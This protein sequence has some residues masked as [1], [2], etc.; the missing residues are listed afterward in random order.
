MLVRNWMTKDV[1]T[2]TPETSLLKIGKLMR[3]HNVRRLPVVDGKG[4]V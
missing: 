1:I 3:D 4:R 2:A